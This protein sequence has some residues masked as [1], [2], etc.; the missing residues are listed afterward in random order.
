VGWRGGSAV[1]SACCSSQGPC[2]CLFLQLELVETSFNRVNSYIHIYTQLRLKSRKSGR[3]VVAHAFNPSTWEAEAGGCLNSRPAWSKEW[4]PGQPG[5]HRETMSQKKQKQKQKQNLEKDT[6]KSQYTYDFLNLNE[7][8]SNP[9]WDSPSHALGQLI[10][11]FVCLFVCFKNFYGFSLI[12]LFIF[13]LFIFQVLSPYPV[14]SLLETPYPIPR[15]PASM[16]VFL[17]PTHPPTPT[18]SPSISL[19]WGIYWA[20]IGPRT[21]PPIDTWQGR[22]LLHMQLEPWVPSCVLLVWWLSPWELGG[23][24]FWLVNIVVLPMGLQT[25]SALSVLSLIVFEK[26]II[27]INKNMVKSNPPPIG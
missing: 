7:W 14:F 8:K 24:G 3:A 23:R 25:P 2:T 9:Q 6:H 20:F 11:G 19:H 15:P 13:N 5:L 12:Y 1:K 10:I 17:H 21:S 18:S 22:P 26:Q 16:R 4:V 27:W